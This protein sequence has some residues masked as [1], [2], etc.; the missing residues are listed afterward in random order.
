MSQLTLLSASTGT[1]NVT[2]TS[3][4]TSTDR[5]ITLPDASGN[6]LSSYNNLSDLNN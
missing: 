6:L 4:S 5:T 2:L 1:G 3:P